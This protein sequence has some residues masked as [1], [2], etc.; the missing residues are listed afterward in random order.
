MPSKKATSTIWYRLFRWGLFSGTV[1]SARQS[2]DSP[3]M[4]S[5]AADPPHDSPALL[6]YPSPATSEQSGQTLSQQQSPPIV[7]SAPVT[8]QGMC[9]KTSYDCYLQSNCYSS[10]A[11]FKSMWIKEAFLKKCAE[12]TTF[13]NLSHLTRNFEYSQHWVLRPASVKGVEVAKHRIGH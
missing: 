4:G 1:N 13:K 12:Q 11:R 3:M 7:P 8:S 6:F 5:P 10:W 9:S 2:V